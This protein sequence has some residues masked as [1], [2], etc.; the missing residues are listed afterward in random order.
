MAAIAS[1]SRVLLGMPELS[2]DP[3]VVVQEKARLAVEDGNMADL[4]FN[5]FECRVAGDPGVDDAP[6][7]DFH[8]HKYIHDREE[9][10]VVL[11]ENSIGPISEGTGVDCRRFCRYRDRT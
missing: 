3:V 1:A 5:P 6:S 10:G 2:E 7:L 4:V 11:R 8:Y 9:G